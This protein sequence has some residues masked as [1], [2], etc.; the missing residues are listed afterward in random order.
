MAWKNL[1]PKLKKSFKLKSVFQ[2]QALAEEGFEVREQVRQAPEEGRR[3]Q[4]PEPVED[5]QEERVHHGRRPGKGG[6]QETR[7]GPG[8]ERGKV[9]VSLR[10]ASR[11]RRGE[12]IVNTSS[13]SPEFVPYKTCSG[14]TITA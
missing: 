11:S 2:H 12:D 7:L 10:A 13:I 5:G 4:L 8:R 6:A 14:C 1:C 9:E 3:V